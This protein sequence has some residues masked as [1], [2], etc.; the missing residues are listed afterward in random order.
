LQKKIYQKINKLIAEGET[1]A[2]VTLVSASEGTPRKSGAKMIVFPDGKTEFTIG[3]GKIELD[4]SLRA[5]KAIK[6]GKNF[7]Y[8]TELREEKNGMLCG[9][10]AEIFIEVFEKKPRVLIFGGGHIALALAGIFDIL[11]LPYEII[12]DREEYSKKERFPRA[13][14]TLCMAYKELEG[15]V[16]IDRN[17]WCVIVTHGHRGDKDVLKAVAQTQ[18]PYIGMIGSRVKIDET[19]RRIESEG[20]KVDKK[21]FFSPIGLD[22]GGDAP[23]EIAL[24]IAAEILMVKNGATGRS[25][26]EVK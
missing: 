14:N 21:R 16:K 6:K 22:L 20:V 3:G 2:V 7:T 24:A 19:V 1:F 4:A 9:G 23:E 11:E 8:K 25:M 17:T 13:Q 15:Q 5:V 10:K 18:T 26:R 12:D